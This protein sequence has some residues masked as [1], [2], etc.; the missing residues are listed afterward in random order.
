M[1]KRTFK[2]TA[3]VLTSLVVVALAYFVFFSPYEVYVIHTGSM[4]PTIPSRSAVI[5]HVG[6]YHVGQVVT[7]T[8]ADEPVTHRLMGI[9]SDG[10]IITKGDGNPTPDPWHLS[11][12]NIIGGVV[13]APRELGFWLVYLREPVGFISV[14][15]LGLFVWSFWDSENEPSARPDPIPA[16]A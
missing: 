3:A 9:R 10:T 7:F 1:L 16:T 5:V 6:E 15:L 13:S 12:S 4:A 8:V 14:V 11:K 2:A